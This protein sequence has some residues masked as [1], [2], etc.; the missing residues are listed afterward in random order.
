MHIKMPTHASSYSKLSPDLGGKLTA[1]LY[2][3]SATEG[4]IASGFCPSVGD[5]A[6]LGT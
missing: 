4:F 2:E 5:V 1:W 6:S 3:L